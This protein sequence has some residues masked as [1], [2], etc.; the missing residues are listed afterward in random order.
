MLTWWAV[1]RAECVRYAKTTA[2]WWLKKI[3]RAASS[4]TG[5][6]SSAAKVED[7][8]SSCRIALHIPNGI[9]CH[10]LPI[11]DVSIAVI[12]GSHAIRP[13]TGAFDLA[14]L[15]YAHDPE[16]SSKQVRCFPDFPRAA[17]GERFANRPDSDGFTT[18]PVGVLCWLINICPGVPSPPG[19][20]LHN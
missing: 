6:V 1:F 2:M 14:G 10:A 5:M 8:Q 4:L 15:V 18:L 9:V 17:Y 11:F 12:R 19:G 20:C 16:D 3:K 7:T 13:M